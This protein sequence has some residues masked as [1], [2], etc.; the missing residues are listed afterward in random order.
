MTTEKCIW[1]DAQSTSLHLI[2]LY[3]D[4]YDKPGAKGFLHVSP[5][6][7]LSQFACAWTILD[8]DGTSCTHSFSIQPAGVGT[9]NDAAADDATT[10]C[11]TSWQTSSS[12]NN[13]SLS[14]VWIISTS[15]IPKQEKKTF[16]QR[17]GA[18]LNDLLHL[19][20]TYM[21]DGKGRQ[22]SDHTPK[23][24]NFVCFLVMH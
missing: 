17:S 20:G 19:N 3:Y 1:H 11:K 8:P 10:L 18:F 6:Y 23:N 9:Y 24:V 2:R 15:C 22:C 12:G 13:I 21:H 5:Y 7:L 14:R 4:K 16:P